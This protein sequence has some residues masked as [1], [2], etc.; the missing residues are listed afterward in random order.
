[1]VLKPTLGVDFGGVI[2]DH[3]KQS[4]KNLFSGSNYLKAVPVEG[5]FGALARLNTGPFAANV[6]MVSRCGELM[7]RKILH[8]LDYQGFTRLTGIP[9]RNLHFCRERY[10]KAPICGKL[11]VTH[12][13]DDRLEVLGYLADVVPNRYL[14]DP[15]T[16]EAVEFQRNMHGVKIIYTW[17][18]LEGLMLK[19]GLRA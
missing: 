15:D 14:F 7:E 18:D 16:A 17:R 9:M 8:W 19:E 10:E 4:P 3:A 5:V 1:M 11:G 12:F 13:I 6:H 2:M